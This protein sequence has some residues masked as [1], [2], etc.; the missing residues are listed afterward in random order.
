MRRA[1]YATRHQQ[2]NLV[3]K[4]RL[5]Y[6]PARKLRFLSL[7]LETFPSLPLRATF[8]ARPAEDGRTLGCSPSTL[9]KHR[10]LPEAA[11]ILALFRMRENPDPPSRPSRRPLRA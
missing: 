11:R 2:A 10:Q 9:V 4:L 5:G 1:T 7:P 6:A 3:P 8:W